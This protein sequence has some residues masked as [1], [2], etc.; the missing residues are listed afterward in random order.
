MYCFH[1]NI[2]WPG[3]KKENFIYNYDFMERWEQL[4]LTP[5]S[6]K[7]EEGQGNYQDKTQKLLKTMK[8]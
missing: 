6:W 7:P 1:H 5:D 3:E 4:Q 2:S 8:A